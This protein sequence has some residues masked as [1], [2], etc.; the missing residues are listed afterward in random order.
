MADKPSVDE[1]SADAPSVDEPRADAP[2]A[3]APSADAPS[4]DEP[5]A[6]QRVYA[7]TDGAHAEALSK[8]SA[9]FVSGD[10][11][12]VRSLCK[13]ALVSADKPNDAERAFASDLL[14]RTAV[15]PMALG[16]AAALVLVIVGL[17]MWAY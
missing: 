2:S 17:F 12:Q 6:V 15:D 3:D 13:A 7:P 4:A 14:A 16:V 5:D 1:P 8:A 9:A 10:F 11:K